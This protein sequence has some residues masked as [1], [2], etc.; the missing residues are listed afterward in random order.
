M[1][2]GQKT[3][4]QVNR[5]IIKE[6]VRVNP[7]LPT[8]KYRII[9]ADPP[10]RYGNDIGTALSGNFSPQDHYPT[11]SIEEICA[12]DIQSIADD[13]AVLFLWVTSPLLE[14][15]FK[16]INEWG[17]K[18]KSSFVWDKDR[19]NFGFYNSVRHEFL[20][21]A[22]KGSC[23]PDAE[24]LVNS[25]QTIEKTKHSAKP[26]EFRAIIDEL[27]TYGNRVEL[28]SRKQTEG[29]TAWGNQIGNM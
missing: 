2:S 15:S 16:V 9:Y 27:Y 17:F 21:V 23:T 12:L 1:K 19:H 25:I 26:E 4:Q 29:W 18:Y 8:N 24:H 20:L 5:E 11:M 13:N 28:F 10:W 6:N 22:T 7:P 14:D 3:L